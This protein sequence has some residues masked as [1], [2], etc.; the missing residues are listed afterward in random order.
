MNPVE[1]FQITPQENLKGWT[2]AM[3]VIGIRGDQL[4]IPASATGLADSVALTLCG[5]DGAEVVHDRGNNQIL[6][7][8]SW[9]REHRPSWSAVYDAIKST[10]SRLCP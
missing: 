3:G 6:V 9:A 4:F 10:A 7:L 2:P 1:L 8:E 5:F